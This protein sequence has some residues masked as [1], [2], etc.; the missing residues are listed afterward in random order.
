MLDGGRGGFDPRSSRVSGGVV[1]ADIGL[2]D[3]ELEYHR[4]CARAVSDARGGAGA[5]GQNLTAGT[6]GDND[7]F[8][9]NCGHEP[10]CG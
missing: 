6:H 10:K 9:P 3:A 4:S 1:V 5:S 2:D 8:R 7:G